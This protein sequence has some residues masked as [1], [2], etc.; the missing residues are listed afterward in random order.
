MAVVIRWQLDE[1]FSFI[2]MIVMEYVH[3]TED[4]QLPQ[5]N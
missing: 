4:L 3:C 5:A 1:N 2:I